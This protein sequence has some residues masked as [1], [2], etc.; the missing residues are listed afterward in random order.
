MSTTLS[1]TTNITANPTLTLNSSTGIVSG[2]VST[3][4]SVNPAISVGFVS[5]G[6]AGTVNISGNSNL[7]LTTQA[8]QTITPTI[9]DQ[10]IAAN[11][12][13]TGEQTIKGDS[14]LISEN[15]KKNVSIFGIT[16]SCL[17]D[18]TLEQ[19]ENGF[20]ELPEQ[21]N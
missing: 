20:I 12:Y 5:I 10:T 13:L 21:I 18:I 6:A 2:S 3:S 8:A 17:G 19:D 15:I 1:P 16:G 7:Q 11:Q 14:N 9:S 4:Q